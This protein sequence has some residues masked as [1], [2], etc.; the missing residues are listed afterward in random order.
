MRNKST[1]KTLMEIPKYLKGN[2]NEYEFHIPW[3]AFDDWVIGLFLR[4]YN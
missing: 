3:I 4:K 1:E 2:Y